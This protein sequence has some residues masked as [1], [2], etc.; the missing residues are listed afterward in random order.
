MSD[1]RP[2]LELEWDGAGKLDEEDPVNVTIGLMFDAVDKLNR[3]HDERI[4][5]AGLWRNR[6][7]VEPWEVDIE[8]NIT[9]FGVKISDLEEFGAM[10]SGRLEVLEER[11]DAMAQQV[12]VWIRPPKRAAR[13]MAD[14]VESV[15]MV[16]FEDPKL[17]EALRKAVREAENDATISGLPVVVAYEGEPICRVSGD[18]SVEQPSADKG[19]AQDLLE[20]KLRELGYDGLAGRAWAFGSHER[21]E[22][23]SKG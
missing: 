17:A 18:G 13:T 20:R 3:Q 23:G 10:T 8:D 14:A 21:K 12:A 15:A 11:A 1:H 5:S 2:I 9:F 6:S 7:E 4:D 22:E 19:R 16:E